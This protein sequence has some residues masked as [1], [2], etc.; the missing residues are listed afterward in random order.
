MINLNRIIIV[1]QCQVNFDGYLDK[2][3]KTINFFL[4]SLL[5]WKQISRFSKKWNIY[6][7]YICNTA[8]TSRNPGLEF[9]KFVF[10]ISS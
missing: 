6:L 2:N 5:E 8:N 7:P 3:I 10:D 1:R 4:K 9:L